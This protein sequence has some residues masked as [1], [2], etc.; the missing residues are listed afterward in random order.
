MKRIWNEEELKSMAGVYQEGTTWYSFTEDDCISSNM[1][2]K[3]IDYCTDE[4]YTVEN[5]MIATTEEKPQTQVL[6]IKEPERE[7]IFKIQVDGKMFVKGKEVEFK[8]QNN[9]KTVKLNN[10]T[11]LE[12]GKEYRLDHWLEGEFIEV[13]MID[14]LIIFTRNQNSIAIL[15]SLHKD[16]LPYTAPQKEVKWKTFLIEVELSNGVLCQKMERYLSEEDA[17]K[18]WEDIIGVKKITE[19]EIEIK[20]VN[21]NN[22]AN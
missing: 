1:L 17:T 22:N 7:E 9:M 21:S 18:T 16:W 8:T 12:V 14:D 20:P 2:G 6:E 15:H 4:G 19:V 10:G 5:W 13:K 11:I 3:K